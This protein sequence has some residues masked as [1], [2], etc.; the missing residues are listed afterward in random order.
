MSANKRTLTKYIVEQMN[1]PHVNCDLGA[2]GFSYRKLPSSHKIDISRLPLAYNPYTVG[3]FS[4][5]ISTI[6]FALCYL[7]NNCLS[8]L[9]MRMRELFLIFKTFP[10]FNLPIL[11]LCSL[12]VRCAIILLYFVVLRLHLTFIRSNIR[13]YCMVYHFD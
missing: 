2:S 4:D 3:D 5:C 1:N 10:I 7:R 12:H 13:F 8:V 11:Y 9:C 6:I